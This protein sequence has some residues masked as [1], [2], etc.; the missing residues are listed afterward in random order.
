MADDDITAIQKTYAA[1]IRAARD[2][3]DLDQ[4]KALR[5]ME[6]EDIAG[7]RENQA[8]YREAAATA[9]ADSTNAARAA[10]GPPAGGGGSYGGARSSEPRSANERLIELA[11]KHNGMKRGEGPMSLSE[12]AE[13]QRLQAG[14]HLVSNLHDRGLRGWRDL[15]TDGIDQ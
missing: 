13:F 14:R 12:I 1:Q 4:I 8:A 11:E 10:Y 6:R 3:G 2:A 9:K 15:D 7:Y 5:A